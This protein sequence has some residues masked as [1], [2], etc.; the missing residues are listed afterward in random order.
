MKLKRMDNVLIVVEDLE[1]VKAF[2]IGLGLRLEGQATVA[3][4]MIGKL[5]GLGDPSAKC[6]TKTRTGSPTSA[7]AQAGPKAVRKRQKR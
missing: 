1:A 4:P 7:G 6:G 5:I 2:F 3:G